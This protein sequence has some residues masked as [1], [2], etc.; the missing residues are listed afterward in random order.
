MSGWLRI[1]MI[2][3]VLASVVEAQLQPASPPLNLMPMPAQVQLGAGQL[4][5]DPLF[6]VSIAGDK[7]PRLE[8]AANRFLDHL[9]RQTG[10]VALDMSLIEQS[11]ARLVIHA[12]RAS[13]EFPELGEDESYTLEVTSAGARLNAPA[14]L[15]VLRG[16]QTF[17]QLVRQTPQGFA[18]PAVS[19][20]DQPRFPWRGL[21]IDV[22][23]HFMPL[24]L[25]R[26]NL[27]GM[28][29]V[30]LN[31]LH[32]HLSDNQGFRI[33]SKK[34]PKL[35]EM[36]SDGLYYTQ[37]EMKDLIEYAADR[38]IRVIPEFDVPGHST[39]W[40]V[41][42]PQL[43][44]GPGPFSVGRHWGVF[45]PVMDPTQNY[46]YKFL[47]DFIGEM[48]RLFPDAYFHIG[49]DEVNGKGWDA[50]PK[51]QEF[52]RT[53]NLANNDAL[54]AYFN[55]RVQEIVHKHHKI[56]LGW[57]EILQPDLPKD[58]VIQSWRGQASLA[59]AAKQGYSGLLSSGYY[60][61][62]NQPAAQHYAVDPM[63]GPT[64][65]LTPEEKKRIL[66]GEACM[67]SEYVSPENV[68]SR[69]WPR[70]AAI[71]ERLWSPQN[72]TDVNS[73]YRRMA[74]I[75]GDLDWLGLTHDSNYDLML[76]RMAGVENTSALR[77]LADVVE[78]VK[79]YTR[80]ELA[81][82]PPTTAT[83][84][85]RLVDAARPESMTARR[86]SELVDAFVAGNIKPGMEDQLKALLTEWRDT[87]TELLPLE[88]QS[89]LVQEVAPIAQN[90]S[91]LGAAGLQALEYM[92]GGQPAPS[93]WVT[94]QT[95]QIEQVKKP[96]SQQVL[97]MVAAPVEKLV[98][99]SAGQSWKASAKP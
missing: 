8:R 47:N 63:T 51:V 44:S 53:H 48:A 23:R 64:A 83:P 57:D 37:A 38:G 74:V 19:I 81:S 94:A 26:R 46:T 1:A 49:G 62:L 73:M 55:K 69:I 77:A 95:A 60:L 78:P 31:V 33:E 54:Q 4:L 13:K 9:R 45:D 90:L 91:T 66:G 70:T 27:D 93:D 92:D 5:V 2:L 67:W 36:G 3:G 16:L 99:A 24:D 12:G 20:Q 11:D 58:I 22:S 43:A 50:N 10:M 6:T 80:Y 28:E 61:D 98:A 56:M 65:D 40:F 71:A 39:A 52:M 17:L 32:L 88:Q 89:A 97:L 21:M 7:D 79:E 59:D 14:T 76:R 86:F 87:Q 41:G 82:T 18:V 85:N 72:V 96:G 25:L 75:S 34:F 15:G 42:Y 29:A 68:D 30:K 35:Q 84:L